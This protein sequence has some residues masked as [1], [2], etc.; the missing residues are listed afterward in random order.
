MQEDV[1]DLDRPGA[2][3]YRERPRRVDLRA[4][5]ERMNRL[6]EALNLAHE[7][8]SALRHE[9]GVV[10]RFEDM[11]DELS[12]RKSVLVAEQDQEHAPVYGNGDES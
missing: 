10:G 4:A 12:H 3:P 11:A 5:G 8:L 6:A 9:L 2:D 7:E 1:D